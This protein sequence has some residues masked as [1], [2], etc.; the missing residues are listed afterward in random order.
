VLVWTLAS[1]G[2]MG[3][4]VGLAPA[5]AASNR[6]LWTLGEA[7]GRSVSAG[8]ATRRIR[9]AFVVA[10][11]ALAVMLMAGAGLLVRSWWNITRVDPGFRSDRILSIQLS[12][13]AFES[14]VQ[15]VGF[16]E[17]ALE[18]IRS[19]PGIESVGIIGDLYVSGDAERLVTPE[20]TAENAANAGMASERLRLRRR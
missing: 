20:E 14:P 8:L 7:G 5:V 9:R 11:C 18:E 10:E 3:L 17:R 2:V 19:L 16:Y 12:T 13:T 6:K 1:S 15:R 4:L